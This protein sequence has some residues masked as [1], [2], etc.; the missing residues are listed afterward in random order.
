MQEDPDGVL[1]IFETK[2]PNAA[3]GRRQLENYLSLEYTAKMGFW[4][5]GVETL[6]IYRLP[7]GQFSYQLSAPLPK[8]TDTFSIVGETPLR[9]DDLE[10]PLP[11]KLRAR[12]DR[13]FGVV[14]AR[15][16]L[17]TRPDQR[18]NQLCNLL[19]TKL[20]SDQHAKLRPSDHLTFQPMETERAT[21]D[22][23]RSAYQRLRS[24]H[25]AIFSSAEDA[26]LRFDNHTIHEVVYELA[27]VRLLDVTPQTI[28]Q[29]FQVFR[30]ANLKSGEGQY[31][32]PS[33]VIRSAIEI[34]DIDYDDRIIDPACGTGGFLVDCYLAMQAKYGSLSEA[35]RQR[36]AATRLF[37]ID[38]DDINVKLARAI[39]QIIGD[40][41]SN[42][43]IGDSLRSHMWATDYPQLPEMLKDETYTCVITNP[44]FG[45]ALKLPAKDGRLSEYTITKKD[46]TDHQDL[47]IGLVFLERCYRLL[48]QGGRLGII[49]PE[50][51]F[52]SSSYAWLR[53]WLE[54]RLLL[55]GMF[56]VPME[57]FQSFCR[58]KTNFYVFE[59][60]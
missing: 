5:N 48:M 22:R 8:P 52:F 32:T 37:G 10:E 17:T 11:A 58:A 7:S 54:G 23:I 27:A 49:L 2:K 35:E 38:R 31:F 34:M 60:V 45:R 59:R 36:W 33:R 4:T 9:F 19:L 57:A 51:Y 21:G 53:G 44:P 12:L 41:S 15:D 30:S 42:I 40:G 14:V 16:T 20:D 3:E 25:P 6:A 50:T 39:M 24:T 1:I 43:E 18:L 28:S 29:A 55:R 13:V 47:E 26:E 56:N 46:R